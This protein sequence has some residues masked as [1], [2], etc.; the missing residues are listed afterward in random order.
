VRRHVQNT[1]AALKTGVGAAVAGCWLLVLPVAGCWV[2]F[3][4]C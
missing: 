4:G 2:L 1:A 3:A